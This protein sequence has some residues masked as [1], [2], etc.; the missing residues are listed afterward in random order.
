MT[1]R[2]RLLGLTAK[3]AARSRNLTPDLGR[4]L[5]L[6]ARYC[7][8]GGCFGAPPPPAG[9]V[10]ASGAL[11]SLA[12]SAVADRAELR[13]LPHH[14]LYSIDGSVG[15]V[16]GMGGMGGT[17]ASRYGWKAVITVGA[18]AG[19][20]ATA[21][22]QLQKLRQASSL[23]VALFKDAWDKIQMAQKAAD[24]AEVKI[25]EAHAFTDVAQ[26]KIDEAEEEQERAWARVVGT[27]S[28]AAGSAAPAGEQQEAAGG[29]R[30]GEVYSGDG[31]DDGDGG[32]LLAA[33][34]RSVRKVEDA[35]RAA[36]EAVAAVEEAQRAY[37]EARTA[38]EVARAAAAEA[39]RAGGATP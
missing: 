37:Q 31:D 34:Q 38:H 1:E 21:A 6:Q 20:G 2:I 12:A 11:S 13:R 36:S 39:R 32:E 8:G 4:T 5:A 7:P 35:K 16:G 28:Q 15:G 27:H 22:Y 19:A 24:E 17:G 14:R 25:N 23:R 30:S 18:A 10:P 9:L 3:L 29:A 26:A 33:V